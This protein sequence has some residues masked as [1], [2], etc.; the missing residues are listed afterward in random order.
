MENYF[1]ICWEIH[2]LTVPG[3]TSSI[4]L[5][6]LLITWDGSILLVVWPG[7]LQI[8]FLFRKVIWKMSRLHNEAAISLWQAS[9]GGE[10][11]GLWYPKYDEGLTL[12]AER[13]LVPC[14]GDVSPCLPGKSHHKANSSVNT[15]EGAWSEPGCP[16]PGIW[17]G[18]TPA[19]VTVWL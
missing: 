11:E 5:N 12:S 19:P 13:C 7:F 6:S 14:H 4:S 17:W 9:L 16:S 15:G 8:N 2:M 3:K 1:L 10:G 18:N